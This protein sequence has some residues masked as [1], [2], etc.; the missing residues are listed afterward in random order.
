M[1]KI[2]Q[3]LDLVVEDLL[4]YFQGSFNSIGEF[5]Y[6]EEQSLDN[7]TGSP[8]R[9]FA[10]VEEAVP[11]AIPINRVPIRTTL[12]TFDLCLASFLCFIPFL[13]LLILP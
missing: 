10:E 3:L 4:L 7:P 13:N 2:G 5:M 12:I 9:V 1:A 8:C 6:F 11:N